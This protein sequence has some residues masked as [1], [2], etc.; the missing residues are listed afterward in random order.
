MGANNAAD[1]CS[2][3]DVFEDS[4][5]EGWLGVMVVCRFRWG[6]SLGD[7]VDGINDGQSVLLLCYI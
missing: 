2:M 7:E 6:T 5:L 4:C 1:D 3:G